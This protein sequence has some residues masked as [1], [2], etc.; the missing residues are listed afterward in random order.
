MASPSARRLRLRRRAPALLAALLPAL[1][2]ASPALARTPL[3]PVA[4][5]APAGAGVVSTRA[6]QAASSASSDPAATA[7]PTPAG[8]AAPQPVRWSPAAGSTVSRALR[9]V[10]VSFDAAVT[11]DPGRVNGLQLE[12]V[13]PNVG[14]TH[15]ETGCPV[16]AGKTVSVPVA[17]GGP[18]SY[19]I[20]YQV[21][22]SRGQV[23]SGERSFEYE[24]EGRVPLA[25]G[26]SG[27]ACVNGTVQSAPQEPAA[28]PQTGGSDS[29][30]LTLGAVGAVVVAAL[31]AIVVVGRRGRR[32]S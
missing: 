21:V 19:R 16:V 15:F 13:G 29:S 4:A 6:T 22:S 20:L 24:P 2:F 25:D 11:G 32:R 23:L 3:D 31:V 28:P 26:S 30:G 8:G 5:S 14:K 7:T 27:P 10:S 1:V 18:G 17:M 9:S 12:V